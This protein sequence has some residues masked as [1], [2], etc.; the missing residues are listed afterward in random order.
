MLL[1]S[2]ITIL[3]SHVTVTQYVTVFNMLRTSSVQFTCHVTQFSD[4]SN[5]VSNR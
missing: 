2:D 1:K 4:I 3:V 5:H